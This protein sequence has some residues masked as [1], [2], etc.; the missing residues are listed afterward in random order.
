MNQCNDTIYIPKALR[1]CK[2]NKSDFW[3][4]SVV[5]NYMMFYG[6]LRSFRQGSF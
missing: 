4:S 1:E 3:K 2:L 5:P 6:E